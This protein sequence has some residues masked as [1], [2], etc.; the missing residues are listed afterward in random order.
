MCTYI[1]VKVD[2]DGRRAALDA[3]EATLVTGLRQVR[4]WRAGT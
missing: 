1:T 2:S 4:D 3:I